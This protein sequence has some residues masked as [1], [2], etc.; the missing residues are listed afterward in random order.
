[1][2]DRAA[3]PQEAPYPAVVSSSISTIAEETRA[4]APDRGDLVSQ[5]RRYQPT[6]EELDSYKLLSK[7]QL[8]F[9]LGP[10]GFTNLTALLFSGQ[11]VFG[12]KP[13]GNLPTE[14]DL[15]PYKN[16]LGPAIHP[17]ILAHFE[18]QVSL[19]LATA[20]LIWGIGKLE[21]RIV[22]VLES[23]KE[24]AQQN[25]I[26]AGEKHGFLIELE[27]LNLMY[28]HQVEILA[29]K[30]R[31]IEVSMLLHLACFRAQKTDHLTDCNS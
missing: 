14:R 29:L 3:L 16:K 5:R 28:G 21:R 13:F 30:E 10:E 1:M 6:T 4:P 11:S 25:S 20:I 24:L 8:D 7:S 9:L 15:A 2:A 18:D 12:L 26:L 27:R 31:Q 23:N 19:E 17:A 22:P